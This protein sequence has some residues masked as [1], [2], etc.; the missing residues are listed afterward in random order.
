MR[1]YKFLTDGRSPFTGRAWPRPDTTGGGAWMEADGQLG[2]CVNGIHA[3]TASQAPFWLTDEL[4][5]VELDGEIVETDV[6]VLASRARLAE[7][8][9]AWNMETRVAFCTDC[10]MRAQQR[11]IR[12][13]SQPLVDRIVAWAPGGWAASVGY[14]AAVL[15]GETAAGRRDGPD[16]EQAFAAERAEQA[17]WLTSALEL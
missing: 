16:Y 13:E 6:A 2:L 5:A 12:P 1:A 11:T 9:A 3:C 4:W 17:A 8:V 14:W 7:P 10:A 15:A